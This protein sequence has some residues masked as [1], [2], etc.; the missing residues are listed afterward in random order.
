MHIHQKGF[1]LAEVMAVVIIVAILAVLASGYYRR[2]VEQSR[3]AE[4]LASAHMV[5]EALNQ[6]YLQ[7]Q[8][9]GIASPAKQREIAQLLTLRP[10][11]NGSAYCYASKFFDVKI[12]KDG[13][14]A[15]IRNSGN[16]KEIYYIE[17]QPH[18]AAN[19]VRD[20]V[21]CIALETQGQDF[22]ESMGYTSC[23]DNVCT[24][25]L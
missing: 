18:Y 6:A 22:C 16:N 13:I 12:D 25:P 8:L 17:V 21:A 7:D 19:S 15:A 5:A 4:G 2:S 11:A 9:D 10:C 24:K 20:R 1:T 3:F 23:T 14:V